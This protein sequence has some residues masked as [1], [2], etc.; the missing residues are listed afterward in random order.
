MNAVEIEAALSS[1]ASSEFDSSEFPF[2]FLR[3]LGNK[4][5]TIKR[6]RKG[7][8]NKSD[9]PGGVLQRNNIHL[10]VTEAEQVGHTLNLLRSSETTSEAKAK[11]ILATDGVTL[12][13]EDLASGESIACEYAKFPDH[14][15]FFLPL[16]GITTVQE[17]KDNPVDVRA[18]GRLNKLY[19][20]LLRE[21][22]DWDTA[23]RRPDMNHFMARLIFCFFAEDMDIFPG[24]GEFTKT[25][26]QMSERD[27]SNTNEVVATL[28]HA[29]NLKPDVR[30]AAGLPSWSKKFPF[31]NGGL[32][33]D[34]IDVPQFSRTARAYLFQAGQLD[35]KAINPD[36]FGS[37]IQAVADDEERGALGMHYTSVPNILKVLNPLFLDDLRAQ[38]KAAGDSKIKLLNIRKRMARIRVFDPACGSGNFLVI[39]YKQMRAIEAEV[40]ARREELNRASDIPLTNFRGIEL[41]SFPAQIARLALII[42]E[43]QCNVLYRGP[44]EALKFV[45][46]LDSRNWI[47][48]GNALRLDWLTLC[49]PVGKGVG[50]VADDAFAGEYDDTRL[51]FVNSG[52]ETY[53]CGNPPFSGS[54][55]QT[56]EQ[57]RDLAVVFKPLDL[58]WRNVDYV[59]GW[60]AKACA[61]ASDSNTRFAF[62]ATNSAFQGQQ[63]PILHSVFSKSGGHIRFAHE[64]F[65]WAN[66]AQ[67][68][69][70]V[71]VVVVGIDTEPGGPR[72]LYS[73]GAVREVEHINGYLTEHDVDPVSSSRKPVTPRVPM[74][75]GVYY[76]KSAGLML[77]RAERD[78]LL[79]AG[80]PM[81]MT[82]R[83]LGS[84]EY[85]NGVERY[86][87]W[88]A[89]DELDRAKQIP[90]VAR[91]IESVERDRHASKD[92][93]MARLALRP[94]Q[95][96]ERKGDESAKI[97]IPI[98]S[99][100]RREYFPAGLAGTEVVPTNKAFFI[101]DGPLWALSVITSSLH[102]L[103][104]ATVCGRLEMRLSYSNTLGWNTF[105]LPDLTEQQRAQLAECAKRI[106]ICRER[107]YPAT[108]ADLYDPEAMPEDLR[109]AHA[110]ND[111]ALERIYI[112]RRF[113]NDSERLSKLFDLYAKIDTE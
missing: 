83:F 90:Q 24:H 57:K 33:G 42:A 73:D 81:S 17:I 30:E 25:V 34:K 23:D 31:V 3:A 26:D 2:S 96:R 43:F 76:S 1:L 21:N 110:A 38:L 50:V 16:A 67:N 55:K 59:G 71:T 54:R 79:Q 107:H 46:P 19:V 93:A 13:A 88:I 56:S 95:F 37:M 65:K 28:F 97:F 61:F 11:F 85:I 108:L 44:Q 68:N 22:K 14:F 4:E 87:L 12:E 40:N 9:V 80:L 112:G 32:F 86:C 53:I 100:E 49:P 92:K 78:E 105:P 106:L 47:T 52:G 20:E 64:S 77:T 5:T 69:A 35:W 91:R 29:M 27:G 10:A 89:D 72:Y 51:N 48:C 58:K 74:E 8:T 60:F 39:A 99:S 94:H 104:V 84:T 109:S 7:S 6:L 101:P 111:E 36:I 66:L 45:L 15:G 41:R 102:L 113:R 75:Y 63:V 18:T 103:W 70:G 82:R 62:V 98:V